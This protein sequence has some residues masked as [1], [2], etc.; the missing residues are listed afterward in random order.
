MK[1]VLIVVAA[2][3]GLVVAVA[4]VGALLPKT[5]E[6][7]RAAK[8]R[9]P[10]EAIWQA[11]TSYKDF[12]SWR[13]GVK[14]VDRLPDREGRP[15]WRE[16]DDHGQVLPIEVV[17]W[18][19]PQ[20]LVTRIAG[21]KLAFGGRWAFEVEPVHGG[22]ELRITEKGEIYNPIFRFMARF[23]FGYSA[24]METYLKALGRKFG[25]DVIPEP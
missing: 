8:F 15:A 9:Q 1:W 2:L 14:T 6:A 16:V 11:I 10:P 13:P 21:P 17:E 5:H 12:P 20:R 22:S 7:S 25:E 24:T 23:F 19:P 3:V 18:L 4:I